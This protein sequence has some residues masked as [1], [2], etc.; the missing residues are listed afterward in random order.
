MCV[1]FFVFPTSSPPPR[2]ISLCVVL[3][4]LYSLCCVFRGVP[5]VRS[6]KKGNTTTWYLYI[7]PSQ[8]S[9]L[10]KLVMVSIC[11][12]HTSFSVNPQP[13]FVCVVKNFSSLHP[14]I[15]VRLNTSEMIQFLQGISL[16]ERN[17]KANLKE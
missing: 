12:K 1:F 10:C 4:F 5:C 3:L 6:M 9:Y 17:V 2:I 13:I 7:I 16:I 15:L 8:L 14:S 11:S